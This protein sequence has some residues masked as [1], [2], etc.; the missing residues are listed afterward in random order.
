[1][2]DR[3]QILSDQGFWTRLEYAATRWLLDSDDP[4]L[5]RFWVDGFL[6]DTATN[7]NYGIDV[8]GTAWVGI[9]GRRQ[10]QY[11]FIASLPQKM[12]YRETPGFVIEQLTLD[13]PLQTLQMT[14]AAR[15]DTATPSGTS[16]AGVGGPS[17]EPGA[18]QE[19]P[20]AN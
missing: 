18:G 12:L 3:Y 19:S 17:S 5:R 11:R 16:N 8:E 1:M 7:T 20:P 10:D 2:S 14:L 15:N 13:E 4:A 9:G 6:P